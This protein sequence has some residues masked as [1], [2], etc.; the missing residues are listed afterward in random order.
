MKKKLLYVLVLALVVCLIPLSNALA[1]DPTYWTDTGNYDATVPD[2]QNFTV[3]NAAQLAGVAKNLQAEP[4]CYAGYAIT[5]GADIDL[6]AHLWLPVNL[7]GT[8]EYDDMDEDEPHKYTAVT[9]NGNG[10]TISGLQVVDFTETGAIVSTVYSSYT[11]CGAAGLFAAVQYALVHDLTLEQPEITLTNSD[12]YYE[13]D[14]EEYVRFDMVGGVAGVIIQSKLRD[15]TV[16]DPHISVDQTPSDEMEYSADSLAVGGIVGYSC[17]LGFVTN[18]AVGGKTGLVEGEIDVYAPLITAEGYGARYVGGAVGYSYCSAQNNTWANIEIDYSDLSEDFDPEDAWS[19]LVAVGG[20]VGGSSVRGYLADGTC[21]INCF[22]RS[23]ISVASRAHEVDYGEVHIGGVAG[24]LDDMAMNTYFAGTITTGM[25]YEEE[26]DVYIG[27]AFG[28]VTGY[29]VVENNYYEAGDGFIGVGN[30]ADNEENWAA[31]FTQNG[32]ATQSEKTALRGTLNGNLSSI[33]GH[34]HEEMDRDEELDALLAALGGLTGPKTWYIHSELNAEYPQFIE[35]P[36]PDRDRNREQSTA[37]QTG[38]PYYYKDNKGNV[39]VFIGFASDKSG[40]MKYIAP[41]GVTVYFTPNSKNFRDITGHW[42]KSNIDFVTE[43]EIFVGTS[44]NIY[45]PDTGMTRAMLVA[46]VGR[47]Y[48][49]SYGELSPSGARMFTDANYSDY[50]G[51][52]LDWADNNGIVF[53]VGNNKFEPHRD[54][55]R[56]EMAAV[57]FR[58]AQ[59]LEVAKAADGNKALT[60]GD[61]DDVFDWAVAAVSYCQGTG[62]V[63]GRTD[64]NFHPHET[65]TRAE[66]AAM[67]Q[68]FVELVIANAKTSSR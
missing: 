40:T 3:T 37:V 47:L 16:I 61:K 42:A 44:P 13:Y 29:Y 21:I 30:D 66:E 26:D 27:H 55:T 49:R 33:S 62:V 36:A 41:E 4:D 58:F 39:K 57:I 68:R 5:L 45:S 22:S 65:I 2:G 35:E 25:E 60:F 46:V 59:Y 10:H 52:Y 43:R 9:F 23:Q 1:A 32:P 34:Q 14:E 20:L 18:C 12:V 48:E 67:V 64:G 54:V 11:N 19:C 15:C 31:T 7:F 28:W 56:E 8:Y 38:L 6:S 63:I 50:Y 53:G 24:W 51:Q 17:D